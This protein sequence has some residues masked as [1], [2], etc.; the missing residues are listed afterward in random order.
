MYYGTNILLFVPVSPSA[1]KMEEELR[2][3]VDQ[4]NECEVLRPFECG[5]VDWQQHQLAVVR[6]G[7]E[8]GL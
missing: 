3:W 7:M 2:G 5:A 6:A 1:H 4:F 8:H